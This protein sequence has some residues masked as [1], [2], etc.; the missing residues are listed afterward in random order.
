MDIRLILE[1]R[2]IFENINQSLL[3]KILKG[4]FGD[5]AWFTYS[6]I[7]RIPSDY[8]KC[9]Y[10]VMRIET[11]ILRQGTETQM[12]GILFTLFLFLSRSYQII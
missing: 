8:V 6:H 7:F 5:M 3:K 11:D 2:I 12:Q 10:P 4:I 9:Q 1:F